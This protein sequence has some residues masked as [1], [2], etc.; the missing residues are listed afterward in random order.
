MEAHARTEMGHTTVSVPKG[1]LDNSVAKV[2]HVDIIYIKMLQCFV[3]YVKRSL[4]FTRIEKK[5]L[6]QQ[7]SG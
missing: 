3:V 4:I 7:S 1:G 6:L 2:Y 5:T